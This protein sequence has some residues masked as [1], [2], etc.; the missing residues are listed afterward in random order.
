MIVEKSLGDGYFIIKDSMNHKHTDKFQLI[1][2]NDQV[3]ICFT[4][5]TVLECETRYFDVYF[6]GMDGMS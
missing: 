1:H 6:S 4:R 5:E 2:I 3:E